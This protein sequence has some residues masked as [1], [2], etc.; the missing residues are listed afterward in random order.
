MD[1]TI[2]ICTAIASV[3]YVIGKA[4]DGAARYALPHTLERMLDLTVD[5]THEEADRG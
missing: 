4:L 1:A 3:A 5:L 2:I